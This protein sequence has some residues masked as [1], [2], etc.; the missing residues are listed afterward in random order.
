M[1]G[2]M[3]L[4]YS[5]VRTA[6]NNLA[7]RDLVGV[8]DSETDGGINNQKLYQITSEGIQYVQENDLEKSEEADLRKE[9]RKLRKEVMMKDSRN[10][11][12][13]LENKLEYVDEETEA[14][15]H[16][17]KQL[18]SVVESAGYDLEPYEK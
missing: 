5:K 8:D 15:E 1:M 2:E 13:E 18:I 10:E 4:T 6:T 14:L 7:E 16:Y 12:K 11:F 17:V 3:D 9:F